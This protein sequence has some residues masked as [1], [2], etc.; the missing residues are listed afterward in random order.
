MCC[1]VR[2]PSWHPINSVGALK[3]FEIDRSLAC[4]DISLTLA[5]MFE[6]FIQARIRTSQGQQRKLGNWSTVELLIGTRGGKYIFGGFN[7]IFSIVKQKT[8][9]CWNLKRNPQNVSQRMQQWIS[10]FRA[11]DKASELRASTPMPKFFFLRAVQGRWW[12]F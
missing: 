11:K 3:T 4:K 2:C 5:G 9:K 1:T 12:V 10:V 8:K 6:N 7:S